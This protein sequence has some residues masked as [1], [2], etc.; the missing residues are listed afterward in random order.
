MPGEGPRAGLGLSEGRD[1]VP[2]LTEVSLAGKID[3]HIIIRPSDINSGQRCVPTKCH[4]SH[5]G[6]VEDSHGAGS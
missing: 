1:K 3:L 5:D 4:G 2:I 6:F